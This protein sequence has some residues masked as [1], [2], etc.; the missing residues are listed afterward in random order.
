MPTTTQRS[1]S[2]AGTAYPNPAQRFCRAPIGVTGFPGETTNRA[3]LSEEHWRADR[4]HA[5]THLAS[6]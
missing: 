2:S 6:A 4:G 3:E 5:A 1:S